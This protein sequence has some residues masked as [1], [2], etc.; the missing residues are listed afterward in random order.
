MNE[1][2]RLAYLTNWNEPYHWKDDE[3]MQKESIKKSSQKSRD[4]AKLWREQ[5]VAHHKWLA[6]TKNEK[7]NDKLKMTL[8]EFVDW[9]NSVPDICEYCEIE[10]EDYLKIKDKCNLVENKTAAMKQLF[11]A[12]SM[13]IDRIDSS[14]FYTKDNIVKACMICNCSK[15]SNIDYD[16]YKLIAKSVMKKLIAEILKRSK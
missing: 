1:N 3:K 2:L 12:N 7:Q 5:N 15:G 16:D 6:I 10:I 14:K 13:T 11:M 8:E 9:W 4:K